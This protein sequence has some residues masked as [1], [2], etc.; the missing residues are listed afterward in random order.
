MGNS[1]NLP[2]V[3]PNFEAD[4]TSISINCLLFA[5]LGVSLV[6][7]LASVVVLQWV[8]DYDT[9]TGRSGSTPE[10]RAKRR[11]FRFA[12]VDSWKMEQIIAALPLLLYSSVA[13][14]WAG[15]VQWIWSIHPTVGAVVVG[16]IALAGLFYASTTL[17][18]AIYVSAPFRTPLSRALY[19]I[20]HT[21]ISTVKR[22]ITWLKIPQRLLIIPSLKIWPIYFISL[23]IRIILYPIAIVAFIV[24][25]APP[26]MWSAS[27]LKSLLPIWSRNLWGPLKWIGTHFLP[28]TESRRREDRAAAVYPLVRQD[29][30]SWL[31]HQLNIS[32]DSYP[33]LLILLREV[34]YLPPERTSAESFQDAPWQAILDSLSR[35]YIGKAFNKNL[36][37]NDYEII[38]ILL[39][40]VTLPG[41]A[42]QISPNSNYTT[43]SSRDEYWTRYLFTPDRE[44]DIPE[45]APNSVTYLLT[46]DVPL[47]MSDSKHELVASVKFIKWRN[48]LGEKNVDIWMHIFAH[49]GHYS[50]QYLVSC[51]QCLHK[52]F[53]FLH[54]QPNLLWLLAQ[55]EE[56]RREQIVKVLEEF[57][58]IMGLTDI[59]PEYHGDLVALVA[60]DMDASEQRWPCSSVC[61]ANLLQRVSHLRDP[62][63]AI[64]GGYACGISTSVKDKLIQAYI[65][66]YSGSLVGL[67][68]LLDRGL[69]A[70]RPPASWDPLAASRLPF[71]TRVEL[72]WREAVRTPNQDARSVKEFPLIHSLLHLNFQ[73]LIGCQDHS[74]GPHH[75]L[76]HVYTA[77]RSLF[78]HFRERIVLYNEDLRGK[79]FNLILALLALPDEV[80]PSN[81]EP[82]LDYESLVT[83]RNLCRKAMEQPDVIYPLLADIVN[84]QLRDQEY[85]PW[86][87]ALIRHA[88]HQAQVYSGRSTQTI[89]RLDDALADLWAV[90]TR[91]QMAAQL[92]GRNSGPSGRVIYMGKALHS[93]K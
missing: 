26:K 34:S 44:M 78:A 71:F 74:S 12:G 2:Y 76:F 82:G 39:R 72:F 13:L 92:S 7:A 46:R 68:I 28:Q 16:G 90:E 89:A 4:A 87:V 69:H 9:A 31:A 58:N 81:I 27:L 86:V 91:Q 48:T 67:R 62:C 33:Q 61:P 20:S 17:L 73:D 93:C 54:R 41:M 85:D 8:A 84:E 18:A 35:H 65:E 51:L 24:F 50:L 25:G 57:D 11:Q 79:R 63:L 66:Q 15:S 29:A 14:F 43:D 64:L 36:T 47:P 19:W 49:R 6:A 30:L 23:L 60:R 42:S 5:S 77:S 88:A 52:S 53:Q 75:A 80:G 21:P 56:T 32:A 3:R 1:S 37:D 83:T 10:D 55:D 22:C 59:S 38:R 40:C 45:G 70:K